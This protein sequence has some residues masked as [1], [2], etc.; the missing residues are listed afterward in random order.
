MV[1]PLGWDDV[2]AVLAGTQFLKVENKNDLNNM[3]KELIEVLGIKGKSFARWEVKRDKF[4]EKLEDYITSSEPPSTIS[5]VKYNELEEKYREAIEEIKK[6]EEDIDKRNEI[7]DQLKKAKDAEEVESIINSSLDEI[8]T[9]DKL[10]K[11]AKAVL[12]KLPSIVQ[13]ALYYHMRNENLEWPGFGEDYKREEIKEAIEEDY[14]ASTDEI[15]E[16]IDEDPKVGAAIKKL[17]ELE[18]FIRQVEEESEDFCN[19][20]ESKY[21]HRLHFYSKRFWDAHLF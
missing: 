2:K 10:V 15:I 13:E 9:F 16:V 3:Q 1:P 12:K 5:I 17:N 20:Y 21:D 18:S 14:L 4:I 6:S 8:E 7:I 19:Y 11:Q